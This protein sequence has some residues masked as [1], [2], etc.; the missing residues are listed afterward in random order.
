MNRK[1]ICIL[2]AA[3]VGKTSLVARYSGESFSS[4]YQSTLGARITHTPVSV[5]GRLRELVIWDIKGETEY[6]HIPLAYLH[7]A[8]GYVLMAD[9]TRSATLDKALELCSHVKAHIGDIPHIIIINKLD[10]RDSWEVSED[11]ISSVRTQIQDIYLCS[12]RGGGITIQA[13][14]ETLAR[15]MWDMK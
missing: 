6:F 13:A 9:G 2:G 5:M 14:L 10:L 3:A 4:R 12:A 8:H 11:Q 1:K 15:K 7:G